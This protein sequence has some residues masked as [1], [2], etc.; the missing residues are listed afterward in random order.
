MSELKKSLNLL[1]ATMIV[2]GNMIGSGI[3]IVSSSMALGLNN[4]K[5]L[6]LC[7]VISGIMTVF[8]ATIFGKLAYLMPFTGGQYVF[9][10]RSF[11]KLTGF[12]YGW[13]TFTVILSGAIAA[14]A[15][16][17]A[18]FCFKFF[19]LFQADNPI[20]FLGFTDISSIELL[21]LVMVWTLTFINARGI[22]MG[23]WVQNFFTISKLLALFVLLVLGSFFLPNFSENWHNSPEIQW[24]SVLLL[25][26]SSAMVG[27]LF[28]SDAWSGVVNIAA[29]IKNPE[30][31]I[32]KAL[33]WGTLIVCVLYFWTNVVYLG[34]LPFDTL[35]VA[36]DQ[37]IGLKSSFALGEYL[38]GFGYGFMLLMNLLIVFSTFGC[39]NGLILGG[40]RLYLAMAEKNHFFP[41]AR[42]LNAYQVPQN[43]LIIQAIW[44]SLLCLSGSYGQ[45]LTYTIFVALVFYVLTLWSS[46]VFHK[47]KPYLAWTDYAMI[48]LYSVL[49]LSLIVG[50]M[51]SEPENT[52][53]GALIVA[54]GLIFYWFFGKMTVKGKITKF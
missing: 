27:S 4:P 51:I 18:K 46:F 44:V 25:S 35:K 34:L 9:L 7:W 36:D 2:S 5:L 38:G 39:N 43:A 6:L 21:A 1:D 45:L 32:A 23:K 20:L 8:S 11:G 53:P 22:Q 12:L 52:L 28:S 48:L 17:F 40:S 30:K 10:E 15:V 14:V 54:S 19:P 33:F 37:I 41:I 50:L 13:S 16:A 3:F 49:A 47:Q 26:L 29:E 31:N 42:K 24:N